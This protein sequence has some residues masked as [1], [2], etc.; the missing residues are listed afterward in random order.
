MRVYDANAINM[1]MTISKVTRIK[2]ELSKIMIVVGMGITL[3]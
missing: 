3:C 2:L 1:S